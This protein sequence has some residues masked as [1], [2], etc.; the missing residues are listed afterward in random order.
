M[1][2]A[3]RIRCEKRHPDRRV[4]LRSLTAKQWP[5]GGLSRAAASHVLSGMKGMKDIGFVKNGGCRKVSIRSASWVAAVLV[6]GQLYAAGELFIAWTVFPLPYCFLCFV[7][8][9]VI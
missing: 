4:V 2:R 9:E 7:V 5:G 3:G 1:G 6:G 8:S